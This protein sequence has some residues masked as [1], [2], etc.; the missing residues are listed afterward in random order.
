M[1]LLNRKIAADIKVHP[2]RPIQPVKTKTQEIVLSLS[3]HEV[4]Q[5]RESVNRKV[6]DWFFALIV[7]PA[8]D[9]R[10]H[11]LKLIRPA[12]PKPPEIWHSLSIREEKQFQAPVSRKGIGSSFAPIVPWEPPVSRTRNNTN[13]LFA[14][15]YLD[16]A[17]TARSA[18]GYNPG[19]CYDHFYIIFH[20]SHHK[21]TGNF[22]GGN[23]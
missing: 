23:S 11:P 10:A 9:I 4:R 5:S 2:Q 15:W 7:P 12:K 3:V 21:R 22:F 6:I 18:V 8:E 17:A 14:K 13:N 16:T 19:G 1:I 20:S